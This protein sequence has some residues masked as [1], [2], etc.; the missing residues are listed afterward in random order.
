MHQYIREQADAL[1][2]RR[3]GEYQQIQDWA[4]HESPKQVPTKQEPLRQGGGPH[5]REEVPRQVPS[6]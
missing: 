4:R 2:Q 1:A 5:K 6:K 3:L